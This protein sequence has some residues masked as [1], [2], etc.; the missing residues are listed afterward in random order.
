MRLRYQ[1]LLCVLCLLLAGSLI[2][3]GVAAA[4]SV[5]AGCPGNLAE[6]RLCA[7][8]RPCFDGMGMSGDALQ[9]SWTATEVFDHFNFRWSRPGRRETQHQVGG[10]RDGAFT[11]NNARRCTGYTLKVQGCNRPFIGSSTCT[12]WEEAR[13]IPPPPQPFGPDTCASGFVWRDAFAGDHVCVQPQVRDQVRADN[14]EAANRRDPFGAFGP[15][16]CK[17]GFV[18]REA[19]PGDLVCVTP[20]VRDQTRGDNA[21]RCSRLAHC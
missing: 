10:G 21:A 5:A 18:W 2:P 11:I 6:P 17:S 12:P 15:N 19:R 16:S 1:S 9:A 7:A 14:R 4:Q 20:A 13:F 8:D 3:G